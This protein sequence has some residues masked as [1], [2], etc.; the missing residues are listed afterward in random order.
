M[1]R[2]VKSNVLRTYNRQITISFKAMPQLETFNIRNLPTD[3]H[4]LESLPD[5]CMLQNVAT[6][7]VNFALTM[8]RG[9]RPFPTLREP[10]R[11]VLPD[12]PIF[13]LEAISNRSIPQNRHVF[14]TCSDYE[15]TGSTIGRLAMAILMQFLTRSRQV[16]TMMQL[17]SVGMGTSFMDTGFVSMLSL[18]ST[19]T[20]PPKVDFSKRVSLLLPNLI[21]S[22]QHQRH[23]TSLDHVNACRCA[24]IDVVQSLAYH[25]A[26]LSLPNSEKGRFRKFVPDAFRFRIFPMTK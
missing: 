10:L 17:A 16:F 19:R 1:S 20:T 25:H 4:V 5:G 11:S 3:I 13:F 7:F 21:Q 15:S 14:M 8:P 9:M 12:T 23:E 2:S 18:W 24:R 22:L 6:V 26:N